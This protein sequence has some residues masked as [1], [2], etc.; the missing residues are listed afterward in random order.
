MGSLAR[1]EKVERERERDRE[2]ARASERGREREG[3]GR[4]GREGE[5]SGSLLS[6]ALIF[7]FCRGSLEK[8]QLQKVCCKYLSMMHLP[9]LSLEITQISGQVSFQH[10]GHLRKGFAST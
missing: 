1:K 7:P 10:V 5:R 4:R 9:T 3:E 8:G 2:R 6:L